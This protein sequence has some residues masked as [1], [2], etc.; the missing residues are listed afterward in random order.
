MF[1]AERR[2]GAAGACL[3]HA[4]LLLAGESTQLSKRAARLGVPLATRVNHSTLIPSGDDAADARPDGT[5]RLSADDQATQ[6][7]AQ[8]LAAALQA[9]QLAGAAHRHTPGRCANCGELCLPLAVY[10]DPECRS[11]HEERQA[12]LRRQG[13]AR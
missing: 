4:P 7:E 11:E 12:V 8:F 10:C 13:R 9:Q 6:R 3:Q 1:V 5:E 2:E